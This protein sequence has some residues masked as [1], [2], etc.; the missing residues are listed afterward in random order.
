MN[1]SKSPNRHSF[2]RESY[3]RRQRESGLPIEEKHLSIFDLLRKQREEQEKDPEW[4][5]N[6]LEFDLRSTQ[7]ILEKAR[8][9][10]EYSQ[11]LYAALCNNQFVK[12]ETWSKLKDE[13][14][15]C[16]WRRA[17]GIIAD[18]RQHGDYVEWYCSGIMQQ[19]EYIS[20]Y[21]EEGKVTDEIRSDLL[22]LG[23]SI[24]DSSE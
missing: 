18:M 2:Q 24:V 23:W 12:N 5:K 4:Q 15:N 1:I 16:S 8:N 6:N 17:G 9:S 21:V 11:N 19:G 3:I 14:W 7:W 20:G 10:I 13:R 22:K